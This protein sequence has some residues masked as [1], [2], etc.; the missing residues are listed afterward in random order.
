MP[1]GFLTKEAFEEIESTDL[2]LGILF[3]TTVKI[4]D[5]MDDL[6]SGFNRW[7]KI[8]SILTVAAGA[9][10]GFFGGMFKT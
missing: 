6:N 8:H 3:D 5:K 9:T 7:R 1:G 2:K 4:Y 10:A